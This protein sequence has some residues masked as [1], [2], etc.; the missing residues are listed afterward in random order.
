MTVTHG[1]DAEKLRRIRELDLP[2]LEINIGS[3][4][5]QV[6]LDGLR[7][8]VVDRTI[9]KRWVHHPVWRV[10]RKILEAEM[11]RHPVTLRY[12]ERL[13]EIRRPLYLATSASKWAGTYL[14]AVTAFYDANTGIKRARRAHGGS[15]P[16]PTPFGKRA[17][18]ALLTIDS[19][20]D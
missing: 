16:K 10:K 9:G 14:S 12:Q 20:S 18:K 6:T 8:L 15:T 5:G 17:P 19:R 3:L 13:I 1:I 2:T 11:G 4:G 7:T